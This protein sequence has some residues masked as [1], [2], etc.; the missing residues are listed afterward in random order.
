MDNSK[1]E[2]LLQKSIAASNRTTAAV[3]AFVVFLFT[4]LAFLTI[5]GILWLIATANPLDPVIWLQ[6]TSAIIWIGGVVLSSNAGWS[7][8]KD[9]EIPSDYVPQGTRAPSEANSSTSLKGTAK[10]TTQRVS[11]NLKLN[12]EGQVVCQECGNWELIEDGKCSACN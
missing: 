1:V 2:E 6:W 5:A 12:A 3:R 10:V 11:P 7:E 9:S 8:L 4:Q